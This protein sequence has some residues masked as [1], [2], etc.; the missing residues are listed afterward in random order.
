MSLFTYGMFNTHSG[1]QLPWK[2][3]CDT[4]TDDDLASL[5]NIIRHKFVYSEVI[6]VP[7]GGLRLAEALRAHCV[8]GYATLVVDDV[9]TT[10][11]SMEEWRPNG[12]SIG[13]VIFARGR[14]PDWVW[15]MF[16][17]NEWTQA[18][19]TGIG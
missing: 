6:G 10:G 18:R 9:M 5:A 13:V 14:V 2:I 19:G 1:L 15:P 12:P 16:T 8:P 17:V 7:R 3:D 11:S 4:L